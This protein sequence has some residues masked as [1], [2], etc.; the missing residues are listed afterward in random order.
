MSVCK[1]V[2]MYEGMYVCKYVSM[3]VCS[4]V[5]MDF[6]KFSIRYSIDVINCVPCE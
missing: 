3:H 1:Y 6:Y 2:V 4:Q 5:C